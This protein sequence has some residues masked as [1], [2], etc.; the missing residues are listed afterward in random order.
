MGILVVLLVVTVPA[1]RGLNQSGSRKAAVSN[2]MG[3]LDR[4]RSMSVSDGRA[5]YV[6]FYATRTPP[7]GAVTDSTSGPW[8]NSYAIYQDA[9]NVSY[10]PVQI[11]PW[12]Q[13]PSGIS[14]KVDGAGQTISITNM[15]DSY[16]T[17][18]G[19][20]DA[21][22]PSGLDMPP[23][24]PVTSTGSNDKKHLYLPFIKF[25]NT[26]AVDEV[27]FNRL[28]FNGNNPALYLRV[29]MFPG[30]LKPDGTEASAQANGARSATS[31]EE[32][33]VNPITGRAKYVVNA[34]DNL[35]TP[36]PTNSPQS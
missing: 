22:Q 36:A 31:L 28:N 9:D 25:S 10:T 8:G 34:A 14:F 21:T 33:D 30:F 23:Q 12:I 2:V 16:G 27:L 15:L 3:V 19:D 35:A 18:P 1:F 11:T 32:I 26:G 4:A 5:T 29:L 24:F 20:P 7:T 6:A 17:P 13:L